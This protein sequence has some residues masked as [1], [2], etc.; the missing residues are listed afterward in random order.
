MKKKI[1]AVSW[2]FVMQI[3]AIFC[4]TISHLCWVS[5]R[6]LGHKSKPSWEVIFQGIKKVFNDSFFYFTLF[7]EHNN[8]TTST[9]RS[10]YFSD[11]NFFC[12][13]RIMISTGLDFCRRRRRKQ[14][15]NKSLRP[16]KQMLLLLQTLFT[17]V[18]QNRKFWKNKE[19]NFF[20]PPPPLFCFC[21]NTT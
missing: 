7:L 15:K 18:S 17:K 1:L 13:W 16:P 8:S 3:S 12:S 2:C 21:F 10:L 11:N 4:Q 5:T 9:P 19:L 14:N 6:Y 20:S